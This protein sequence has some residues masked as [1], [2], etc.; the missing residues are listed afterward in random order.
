MKL[1]GRI[2]AEQL[3][4]ERLTNIER[5]LVV[6]VSEMQAPP[7]RAPRRA[8][9]FAGMAMAVALA[10]VVGWKLHRP[11]VPVVEQEVP[12][13]F[14][15]KSD[16]DHSTLDLGDARVTSSAGTEARV[17]RTA[18]RTD[19]ALAHGTLALEVEHKPGRLL[20]VHAGDDTIEDVGT[21]FSVAYDGT[22]HLE[23]RVTEGEVKVTHAGNDVRV[24][25]SNAWTIELGAISIAKLDETLAA[26]TV[27]AGN[28]IQMEPDHVAGD[29]TAKGSDARGS[30]A[31]GTEMRGSD[32]R[33]SASIGTGSGTGSGGAT[34]KTGPTKI[35]PAILAVEL[36]PLPGKMADYNELLRTAQ[37]DDAKQRVMY[38]I[39]VMQHQQKNDGAALRSIAGIIIGR[40]KLEAYKDAM[41][42]QVRV[43]C[44]QALDDKTNEKKVDSC[45]GAAQDYVNNIPDGPQAGIADTILKAIAAGL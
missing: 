22:H 37:G 45:R 39:A 24:T 42:L 8:L 7:E 34:H 12:Q 21:K 15:L 14:A 44:L 3:E 32:A 41:W 30:D 26:G 2:P 18:K 6:A 10:G 33:G 11:G 13:S 4:D 9:V 1:R 19:L 20:V 43:T 27:V 16:G 25:A 17:E 38:S 31:R 40:T 28:D 36:K 29:E 35:R 23:V 5:K